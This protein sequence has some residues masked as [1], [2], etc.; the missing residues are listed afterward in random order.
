MSRAGK[1]FSLLC[2]ESGCEQATL[3]NLLLRNYLEFNLYEQADTLIRKTTFPEGD[4]SN[5][6]VTS[7]IN[8]AAAIRCISGVMMHLTFFLFLV[9][10]V[11][12]PLPLLRRP[13]QGRSA[14][15]HRRF[16]ESPAGSSQ[17]PSAERPGLPEDGLQVYCHCPAPPRRNPRP[18]DLFTE[19]HD[20]GPSA[21]PAHCTGCSRWRSR[22]V[23]QGHGGAHRDFQGGTVSCPHHTH[24]S[25]VKCGCPI[26]SGF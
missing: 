25:A 12:C 16:Q 11:A 19:G 8:P 2:A 13:R 17:G 10:V 24:F 20:L 15:V 22:G 6:Q 5:N 21:V 7:H 23:S 14:R 1:Y 18:F 9:C 3:L 26:G 4:A